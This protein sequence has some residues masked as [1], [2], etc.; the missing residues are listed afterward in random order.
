MPEH[1]PAAEPRVTGEDIL[2]EIIRNLEA[3]L[4]QIRYTTLVPAVF[5][6][7][8]HSEDYEPIRPAVPFL[9]A[10]IRRV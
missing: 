4:F 10:A 3:G 1:T 5:R 8:L 6:V 9:S 7:Y 2:S